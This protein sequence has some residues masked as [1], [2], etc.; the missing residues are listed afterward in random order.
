MGLRLLG[1]PQSS[2]EAWHEYLAGIGLAVYMFGLH[3][4]LCSLE[5]PEGVP[6]FHQP[7]WLPEQESQVTLGS[8][9]FGK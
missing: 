8:D 1:H 3:H 7:V 5:P 2:D 6:P 9:C 4:H